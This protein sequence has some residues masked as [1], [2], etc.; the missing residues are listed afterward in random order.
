LLTVLDTDRFAMLCD[1]A[2]RFRKCKERLLQAA[3]DPVMGGLLVKDGMG[4]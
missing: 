4:K 2:G 1:A 3:N